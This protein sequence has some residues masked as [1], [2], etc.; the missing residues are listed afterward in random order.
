[1][2][3]ARSSVCTFKKKHKLFCDF[4]SSVKFLDGYASYLSGCITTV[5]CKQQ[6]LKTHDCHFLLQRVCQLVSVV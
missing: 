6:S 4:I 2:Q 5:G 1:M 3:I